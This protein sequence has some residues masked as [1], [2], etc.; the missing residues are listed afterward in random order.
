MALSWH[1][2][3]FPHT[4]GIG[5]ENPGYF[6]PGQMLVTPYADRQFGSKAA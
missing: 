4:G 6:S 5:Q 1:P 2:P 3:Q